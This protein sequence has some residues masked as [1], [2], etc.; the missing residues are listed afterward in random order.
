MRIVD[1]SLRRQIESN[2][3]DYL[4]SGETDP[5]PERFRRT[6]DVRDFAQKA[7]IPCGARTPLGDELSTY[8]L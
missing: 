8:R 2:L 5:R 1:D 6:R 4:R 7:G 3:I